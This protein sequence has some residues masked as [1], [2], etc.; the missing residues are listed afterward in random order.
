[1]V[2]GH[3]VASGLEF[4]NCT[5]THVTRD[6]D[7]TVLPIPVIFPSCE[8]EEGGGGVGKRRGNEGGESSIAPEL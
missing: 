8:K 7:T 6:H 1:M 5:R 4:G 3:G 2:T